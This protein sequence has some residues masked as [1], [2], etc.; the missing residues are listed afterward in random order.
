MTVSEVIHVGDKIEI[1]IAQEAERES[2]TAETVKM[3]KSQVLDMKSN[4]LLQIAMP[5]EA[6]KLVMLSLGLRYEFVFYSMGSLYRAIGQIKERYKKDNYYMLDIE[7]R[8]E[9]EKYQRRE[10]FRFSCL[11]D[12]SFYH[13]PEE[14]MQ[15]EKLEDIYEM[16]R[17]DY[18]EGKVTPGKIV[19]L[20]GGGIRFY[21]ENPVNADACLLLDIRLKNETMDKQFHIPARVLDCHRVENIQE[22]RYE[23]RAKFF[24]R[25]DKVR[26]EII[27]YIFEEERKTRQRGK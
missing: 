8:S 10:F 13:I 9:L 14:A 24:I 26:E 16:I 21:T 7:L 1:R 6:G 12:F 22:V 20:S 4:G 5:T 23:L 27:H 25:D 2:R 3:Y 19:D 17:D 15:L 18:L 11:L